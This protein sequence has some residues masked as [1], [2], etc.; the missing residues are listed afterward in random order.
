[1]HTSTNTAEAHRDLST[2][3]VVAT[4]QSRS[5]SGMVQK[6][7]HF[8]QSSGV[9]EVSDLPSFGFANISGG[10]R[11]VSIQVLGSLGLPVFIPDDENGVTVKDYMYVIGSRSTSALENTTIPAW[12][13]K[14]KIVPPQLN[15]LLSGGAIHRPILRFD[16]S[17]SLFKPIYAIPSATSS[18]REMSA[19]EMSQPATIPALSW[20]TIKLGGVLDWKIVLYPERETAGV[21]TSRQLAHGSMYVTTHDVLHAIH[22]ALHHQIHPK[23]WKAMPLPHQQRTLDTYERRL[24]GYESHGRTLS[25][26]ERTLKWIDCLWEG[27]MFQ[28]LKSEDWAEDKEQWGAMQLVVGK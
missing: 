6:K 22:Q 27:H 23:F 14:P 15:P 11:P 2:P 5:G 8:L 24:R 20:M 17:D 21:H 26:Q 16:L 7:V 3:A 13:V 19:T 4:T 10:L 18:N 1:M 12:M 28:G 25:V 9:R